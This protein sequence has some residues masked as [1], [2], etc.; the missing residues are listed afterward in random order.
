[1]SG[2]TILAFIPCG[3]SAVYCTASPIIVDD[4]SAI[5]NFSL[6]FERSSTITFPALF[7]K[8]LTASGG[9]ELY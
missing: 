1:M 8:I 9:F 4:A 5:S 3:L 2:E 7:R 6:Y